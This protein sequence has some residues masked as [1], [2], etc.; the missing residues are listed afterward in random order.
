MV[1][2]H[3]IWAL[4]HI[5][6]LSSSSAYQLSLSFLAITLLLTYLAV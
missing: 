6:V 2:P 3:Y 4:G 5:V 1:D